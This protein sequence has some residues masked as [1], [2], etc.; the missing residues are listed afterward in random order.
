MKS[1]LRFRRSVVAGAASAASAAGGRFPAVFHCACQFG[2]VDGGAAVTVTLI[3]QPHPF[4]G[5][6]NQPEAG[7]PCGYRAV[8]VL[9]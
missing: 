6:V 8:R 2:L 4:T 1:H 7:K 3:V 5:D 9:Q